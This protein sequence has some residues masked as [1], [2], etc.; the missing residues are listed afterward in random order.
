MRHRLAVI[1]SGVLLGLIGIWVKLIG[2]AV[3][4]M[5]INWTRLALSFLFVLIFLAPFYRKQI[6]HAKKDWKGAMIVGA[7]MAIAFSLFS[8][9]NSLAPVTNVAL[10]TSMYAVI[11]PVYAWL[12]LKEKV[13]IK[14]ITA[15]FM[16][17]CGLVIINPFLPQYVSGNIISIVH[18]FVFSAFLVFLRKEEKTH[19]IA[20]VF[21]FFL[22][23]ALFLTPL[24]FIFGLGE[25]AKVWYLVLGLGIFSTGLPYALLTY[26]LEKVPATKAAII[27]LVTLPL[28]SIL[29]AFL[30]LG[31]VR[32]FVT[33]LGGALL[34][35]AGVLAIWGEKIKHHF[36]H[37]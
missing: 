28:S 3:P 8:T 12:L 36:V 24:P 13:A 37:F 34:L 27:I 29:F 32:P 19:D 33:Y 15:I 35:A 14:H 16:A 4:I 20:S 9:A 2:K 6:V 26:G 1:S 7:L 10:I 31:E 25:I 23:A 18:P 17:L 22:F 5:T 21:W 11:T 30:I